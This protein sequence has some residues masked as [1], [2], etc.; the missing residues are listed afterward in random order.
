MSEK[1]VYTITL[2][3]NREKDLPY[4]GLTCTSKEI[5]DK[6]KVLSSLALLESLGFDIHIITAKG[7]HVRKAQ[8]KDDFMEEHYGHRN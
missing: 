1:L 8:T 7:S 2:R 3:Q 5:E 4:Y 6:N